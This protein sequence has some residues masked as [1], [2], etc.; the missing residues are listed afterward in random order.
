MT[1]SD[2]NRLPKALPPST[3]TLRVRASPWACRWDRFRPWQAVTATILN[4]VVY[5]LA[6]ILCFLT[7]PLPQLKCPAGQLIALGAVFSMK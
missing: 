5:L 6:W 3:I 1:S 7:L 4:A 2:P